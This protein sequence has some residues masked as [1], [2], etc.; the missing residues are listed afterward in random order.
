MKL[1][2]KQ[3]EAIYKMEEYAGISSHREFFKDKEEFQSYWE[4]LDKKCKKKKNFF[5]AVE[6]GKVSLTEVRKKKQQEINLYYQ[7]F[8]HLVT[9]GEKYIQKYRPSSGKLLK[10]LTSKCKNK[11]LGQKVF[12]K[13]SIQLNDKE[14][15]SAIVDKLMRKG[16]SFYQIKMELAKKYFPRVLIDQA[17]KSLEANPEKK[18]ED[19]ELSSQIAKMRKR[20][21]SI[22]EISQ[23]LGSSVYGK[24]EVR[25]LISSTS[26]ETSDLEILEIAV[27][28]L[29]RK[30]VETKKIIQRLSQ[31]GF[32]YANIKKVLDKGL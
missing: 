15:I 28:K 12:D 32:S 29:L 21:K 18:I 2:D 5:N 17:L 30:K 27:E 10:Q 8:D 31:K 20:G 13:L 7:D 9:Y 26:T 16:K 19:S 3:M 23:K 14:Q 6:T 4:L 25:Q 11:D 24:E 22:R 1:S